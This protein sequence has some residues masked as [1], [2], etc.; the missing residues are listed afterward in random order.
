MNENS[1]KAEAWK[2]RYGRQEKDVE[3]R[4]MFYMSFVP[5]YAQI[6]LRIFEF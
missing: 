5:G 3:E 1:Q 6:L 2:A 4:E